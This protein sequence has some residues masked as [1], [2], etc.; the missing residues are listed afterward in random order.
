MTLSFLL[1]VVLLNESAGA[2]LFT[3][4]KGDLLMTGVRAAEGVTEAL[5]PE[6]E[7][8]AESEEVEAKA[9]APWAAADVIV[10]LVFVA[11]FFLGAVTLF[12]AALVDGFP[13]DFTLVSFAVVLEADS[14][15][16]DSLASTSI[17][18]VPS[19]CSFLDLSIMVMLNTHKKLLV[20]V[21]I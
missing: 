13:V 2:L 21:N 14:W 3:C 9:E 4:C 5:A 19:G 6:L 15:Q 11:L 10:E 16:G 18:V 20:L 12:F 8:L 7:A 17:G 1:G